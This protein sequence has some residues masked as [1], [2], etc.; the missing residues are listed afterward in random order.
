MALLTVKEVAKK[1]N[2][3]KSTIYHWVWDKKIPHYRLEIGLRFDE[4]EIDE[5]LKKQR[6]PHEDEEG[7]D[8]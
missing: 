3:S 7:E 4:D 5:W 1:L 2:V 8:V 6:V